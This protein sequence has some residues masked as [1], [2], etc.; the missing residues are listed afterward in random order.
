MR[1]GP[2]KQLVIAASALSLIYPPDGSG[3]LAPEEGT[4]AM[5]SHATPAAS[6][7]RRPPRHRL[8]EMVALF[9]RGTTLRPCLPVAAVVGCVLSAINEGARIASGHTG[10]PT[11]VQVGLNFVVPFLVSSY[12][13]LSAAHPAAVDRQRSAGTL[14]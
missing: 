12:G 1:R 11:W 5:R 10:W 9:A 2:V 3:A 14:P 4:A 7:T 13:Y 6:G 8:A